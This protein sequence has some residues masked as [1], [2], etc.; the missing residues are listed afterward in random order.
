MNQLLPPSTM[1]WM[2]APMLASRANNNGN[3]SSDGTNQVRSM[4]P[5]LLLGRSNRI[6]PQLSILITGYFYI[7][8]S[9]MIKPLGLLTDKIHQ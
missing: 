5:S 9:L 6:Q 4:W 7:N 3:P 8:A 1:G 2:L